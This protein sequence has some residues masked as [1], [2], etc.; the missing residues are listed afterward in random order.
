MRRKNNRFRFTLFLLFAVLTFSLEAQEYNVT[1]YGVKEG[2]AQYQVT[3]LAQDNKG[4]IWIGT[5]GGISIFDGKNFINITTNEGFDGTDILKKIFDKNNNT[6]VATRKD[7]YQ[8]K[9]DKAYRTYFTKRI[10]DFLQINYFFRFNDDSLLIL[11]YET[12]YQKSNLLIQNIKTNNI[13]FNDNAIK[14]LQKKYPFFEKGESKFL[15]KKDKLYYINNYA[16]NLVGTKGKNSFLF[17]WKYN[18]K[19]PLG[20]INF[21]EKKYHRIRYKTNNEIVTLLGNSNKY[22]FTKYDKSKFT[23]TNYKNNI[24]I[25][26]KLYV[27]GQ[28]SFRELGDSAFLHFRSKN[29]YTIFNIWAV[30]ETSNYYYFFGFDADSYKI[31]K[32]THQFKKLESKTRQYYFGHTKLKKDKILIGTTQGYNI[33]SETNIKSFKDDKRNDL[34]YIYT[35]SITQDKYICAF[36]G[37]YILHPNDSIESYLNPDGYDLAYPLCIEKDKF[38][39]FWLTG[40]KIR[41][42]KNKKFHKITGELNKSGAFSV[43]KDDRQ[44]L[45][46]GTKRGLYFY[47]YKKYKKI[48]HYKLNTI[49]TGI[50]QVD[51]QRLLLGTIKGLAM[52][53]LNLFY[54]KDSLFIQFFDETNDFATEECQQNSFYKDTKGYIWLPLIN[55]VIRI[56][57]AYLRFNYNKPRIDFQKIVDN[58]T[59]KEYYPENN[60]IKLNKKNRNI[61]I[62]YT[63]FEY[64]NPQ[65]I[66]FSYRIKELNKTW[67]SKT[68]I[69][70][71]SF[72][73]LSG[74]KY[75]LQLIAFS[76]NDLPSKINELH[77]KIEKKL[78]EYISFK[79]AGLILVLLI[80]SFFIQLYFKNKSIKITEQLAIKQK[81]LDL[82]SKNLIGLLDHHF[83]FNS[84]AA[85]AGLAYKLEPEKMYQA[86]TQLANLLRY[87]LRKD[88]SIAVE[89]LAEINEMENLIKIQSLR[90]DKRLEYKKEIENYSDLEDV[91]IPRLFLYH[92]LENAIK[93]STEHTLTKGIIVLRT[94]K[95]DETHLCIEVEDNGIGSQS[96]KME[97]VST[98]IGIKSNEELLKILNNNKPENEQIKFKI[99]FKKS[100][101]NGVKVKII[102]PYNFD[103]Y[104][105]VI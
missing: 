92:F 34:S 49:I 96:I 63:A 41:K 67:S 84:I 105:D 65:K 69:R 6:W 61:T 7:I 80:G 36:K 50:Y 103:F 38:G 98:E 37:L 86:L 16:F 13:L 77:F 39:Y 102:V 21:L 1:N 18:R 9:N 95:L 104:I 17:F 81:L 72:S 20:L 27:S 40:A 89:L 48:N 24:K 14:L 23:L 22:T 97:K 5:K 35:D 55:E 51:K 3:T 15:I 42:F 79:I 91:R 46:F 90:F 47:D 83:I 99:V 73:N 33:V 11:S 58:N 54:N 32:K 75:T 93:Y 71:I 87:T 88:Q 57:T 76:E 82:E 31:N 100:P 28:F 74:G 85:S 52:L 26:N 29:T 70:S 94:Y 43:K 68:T 62:H 12:K 101:E 19:D 78:N 2:L 4:Y 8:I 10:K 25:N 30:D 64:N 44:N 45:W 59:G 56:D 66:R 53:D 60:F